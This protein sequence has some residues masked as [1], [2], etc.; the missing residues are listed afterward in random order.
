MWLNAQ[1]ESSRDASIEGGVLLES[2]PHIFLGT[3]YGQTSGTP[4]SIAACSVIDP[5]SLRVSDTPS[6]ATLGL[7]AVTAKRDFRRWVNCNDYR[8]RYSGE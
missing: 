3:P 4:P 5:L 1:P 7:C 8:C 6:K 2:R